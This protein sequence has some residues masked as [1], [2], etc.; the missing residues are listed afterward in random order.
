MFFGILFL[1]LIHNVDAIGITP[2]RITIYYEPNSVETIE[3]A[4][5][6][7]EGYAYDANVQIGGPLKEIIN[8]PAQNITLEP[9]ASYPFSFTTTMPS[10]MEMP[11]DYIN[12]IVAVE[13]P[14]PQVEDS[15]TLISSLTAI[16]GQLV[17][18]VPYEGYYLS[19][20]ISATSVSVG[21]NAEFKIFL[22]N[23]GDKEINNIVGTIQI[24]DSDNKIVKTIRFNDSLGLNQIKES[25]LYW[26]TAGALAGEY[27][28]E[29]TLEYVGKT[30]E[31]DTTFKL[32]DIIIEIVNFQ[33]EIIAGKINK[34]SAELSS[35][36]NNPI[37]EAFIKLLVQYGGETYV[38]KS[39]DFDLEPWEK[40]EVVM[41]VDAT[42][43]VEGKYPAEF[44]VYYDVYSNSE[45]FDIIVKKFI[46]YFIIAGY[47][48][49]GLIIIGLIVYI[50]MMKRSKKNN[51]KK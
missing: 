39:E 11:G 48:I 17:I 51:G 45:K 46:D 44:S 13:L 34:Y 20:R 50:I 4:I 41:Y 42:H 6:N 16:I 12:Q 1:L 3:F 23:L 28:A 7:S 18:R 49:L 43:M 40:K 21:K 35:G 38:Y 32:G 19:G 9:G 15:G 2:A 5:F 30:F 14:P 27:R 36:W 33:K 31:T 25:S 10:E 47:S 37:N 8:F 22:E 29:L 24:Y 26:N